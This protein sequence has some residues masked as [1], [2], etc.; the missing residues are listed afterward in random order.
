M[1]FTLNMITWEVAAPN[2]PLKNHTVVSIDQHRLLLF[3]GFTGTVNVNNVMMFDAR[4]PAW[5]EIP[6]KGTPPSCRNGH[7]ALLV[8]QKIVVIGG[9]AKCST[10]LACSDMF[11]LD[12]NTWTWNSWPL[13]LPSNMCSAVYSHGLIYVFRGG[14]GEGYHNDVYTIHPQTHELA[15]VEPRGPPPPARAN[16]AGVLIGDSVYIAGGWNGTKRMNDMHR[17]HI[18]THTWWEVSTRLPLA[19]SGMTLTHYRMANVKDYIVLYGG[20][21]DHARQEG[22]PYRQNKH[23]YIFDL[24]KEEWSEHSLDNEEEAEKP[25]RTGHCLVSFRPD[26]PEM[27]LIGGSCNRVYPQNSI[28]INLTGF[29]PN[30]GI[31]ANGPSLTFEQFFN[32]DTFSD[33][34]FRIHGRTVPAH[35]VVLAQANDRFRLMFSSGFRESETSE[36]DIVTDVSYETFYDMLRYLYTGS[37]GEGGIRDPIEMLCLSNEYILPHLK[38][39]CEVALKAALLPSTVNDILEYARYYHAEQLALY[40]IYYRDVLQRN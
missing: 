38:Q 31:S 6:T 10:R 2:P 15:H 40:C 3:G 33:V 28:V 17:F 5:T 25:Y 12:L 27:F 37:L 29:E 11:E 35:R 36:I 1:N 32:N 24:E 8:N 20:D 39:C 4:A 18:P 14:D 16:H 13:E 22:M 26:S 23:I 19:L 7:T 21:G 9:W 34:R 30:V